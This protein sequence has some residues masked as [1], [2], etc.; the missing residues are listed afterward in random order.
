MSNDRKDAPSA[1]RISPQ[2][3]ETG[4]AE[5]QDAPDALRAS[6][7][8]TTYEEWRVTGDLGDDYPPYEFTWS[9]RRNPHLGDPEAGARG[10]IALVADTGCAWPDG[11]HLHK[12][13]V[14]VTDWEPA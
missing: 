3:D 12:R 6:G 4:P 10:F 5:G 1:G 14:T 7:G 2:S 13:T 9:P 11:P 8:V